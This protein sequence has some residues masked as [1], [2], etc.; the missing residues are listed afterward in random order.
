M[1]LSASFLL[2]VKSGLM[3]SGVCGA[4]VRCEFGRCVDRALDRG[5]RA[6]ASCY[7]IQM[8]PSLSACHRR[9]SLRELGLS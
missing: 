8:H 9:D 1:V 7:F 2:V 4:A 3:R 6:D 5:L